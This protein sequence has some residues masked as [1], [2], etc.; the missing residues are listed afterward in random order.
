MRLLKRLVWL[1]LALLSVVAAAGAVYVYRSFPAID[2]QLRASNLNAAVSVARDTS[3]VTHITAT[4]WTAQAL[5]P[6]FHILGTRPGG[7]KG[8]PWTPQGSLGWSVMMA[9]DLGGNWGAE[10]ARLTASRGLTTA[11][12]WQLMPP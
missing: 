7:Q 3:D 2:G 5:P 4:G 6:E 9:L 11:Q 8:K 12:L 1:L 10:W